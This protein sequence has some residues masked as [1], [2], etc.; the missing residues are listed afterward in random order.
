MLGL[1]MA[2]LA[3]MV[4]IGPALAGTAPPDYGSTVLCKYRTNSPGP[5]FTARLKRI[6]VSPPAMLAKSGQQTVGWRFV[7][8]R[9]IDEV[10]RDYPSHH[11]TYRSPI[12]KATATTVKAADFD[13]MG[14]D[15][16]LPTTVDPRDVYYEVVI[17]MTWY[18]PDG[19]VNSAISYLM[20]DYTVRVRGDG[21]AYTEGG[22]DTCEG[23]HWAAV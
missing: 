11:V 23:A 17:R 13:S 1:V 16:A 8:R 20:P 9:T 6:N 3:T 22:Y 2:A 19:S 12:Q 14:V 18:R 21:W 4:G 5:A 7:V 10:W 15:V